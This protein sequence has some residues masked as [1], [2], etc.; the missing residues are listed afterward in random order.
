MVYWLVT[1]T[2]NFG[3]RVEIPF[4]RERDALVFASELLVPAYVRKTVIL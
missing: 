1:F 2:M 4:T 3:I